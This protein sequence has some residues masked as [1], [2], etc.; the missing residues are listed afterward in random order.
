MCQEIKIC[1]VHDC[2][3][4]TCAKF[5]DTSI[6]PQNGPKGTTFSFDQV[7]QILEQT[8]TGTIE[9][10]VAPPQGQILGAEQL[11]AEGFAP[12]TYEIRF[13]LRVEDNPEKKIHF[14]TGVYKTQT[15]VCQGLCGSHHSHTR[16]LA[17]YNGNFTVTA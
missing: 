10:Q 7:F 11:V 6:I 9:F 16:T 2:E 1:P 17:L 15:A 5:V 14:P 12:G 13:S 4:T 3:A 8:G